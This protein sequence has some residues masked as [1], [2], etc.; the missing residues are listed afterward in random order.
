MLIDG[1]TKYLSHHF[2][3]SF[4]KKHDFIEVLVLTDVQ[5]GH[6]CC[7]VDKL[8]EYRD[9]ILAEP[10]RFCLFGGDMIDAWR[11]GSPGAGYDNFFDPDTQVWKFCELIAPL[12]HRVLGSVG[13][14]HERRGLAGGIDWGSLLSHMLELPYSAGGQMIAINYG[15]KWSGE[16]A[17]PIYLWHGRGAARTAGA[18]VNMTLSAVPNDEALAYFSGHIHNSHAKICWRMKRDPK[19]MKMIPERYYVVSASSFLEHY[20]SYNEVFGGTYSGLH[21]PNLLIHR[22][23]RYRVEL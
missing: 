14:N 7:K 19:A 16:R 20:G 6:K 3:E 13:G 8:I 2:P 22:D 17:F 21:M 15:P 1:Q 11:I 5:Y 12:R 18:Q 10:N 9:W 4:S 23:G